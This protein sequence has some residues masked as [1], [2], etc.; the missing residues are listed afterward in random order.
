M[1]VLEGPS[2]RG[3]A[4]HLAH[5]AA[6][7][8]PRLHA[9]RQSHWRIAKD[10]IQGRTPAV[11]GIVQKFKEETGLPGGVII[12]TA[13]VNRPEEDILSDLQYFQTVWTEVQ[14]RKETQRR[15][16]CSI[17]KSRRKV[18]ARFPDGTVHRD[19]D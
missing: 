17:A 4:H 13:A 18:V 7:T 14:R 19:Q 10:R 6:G 1:Q 11:R 15:R 5:F 9:D 3:R 2:A 16:R 8:V 12:R